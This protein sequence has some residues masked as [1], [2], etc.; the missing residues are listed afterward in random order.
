MKEQTELV[1]D[2]DSMNY[3]DFR[4]QVVKSLT[5]MYSFHLWEPAAG[6]TGGILLKVN[7][8]SEEYST[9][10]IAFDMA[11][12]TIDWMLRGHDEDAEDYED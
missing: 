6:S 1:F 2:K 10:N 11:R 3:R 4:I 12:A 8:K 7:Y 9:E 5:A